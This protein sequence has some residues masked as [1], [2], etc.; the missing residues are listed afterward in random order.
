M[1]RSVL[2]L[3]MVVVA[4]CSGTPQQPAPATGHGH[5]QAP[6][7]DP[8]LVPA[9]DTGTPALGQPIGSMAQLSKWVRGVTGECADLTE[10]GK[11]ELADYLG[12]TRVTWYGPFVAEWAT[13]RIQPHDKLGLVL[14]EPG[15]QRALQ[16][17][18]LR[19]L[20][21]GEIT[22]NPDWAFGNGFAVTAGPLGIERLGL[23][24]L[25]CE[26]VEGATGRTVPA[27]VAGCLYAK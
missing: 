27:D 20:E 21:S 25:R 3:V 10:S 9:G 13:C 2:I 17:F 18:W 8:N 24:Y 22:D 6:T 11:D 4:G 19:G 14:F 5:H 16:E 12:P 23:Y 26:P 1:W 15:Q 7:D